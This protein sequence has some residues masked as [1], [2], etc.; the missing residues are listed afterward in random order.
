MTLDEP[1][2]SPAPA[3]AGAGAVNAL[4][5]RIPSSCCGAPAR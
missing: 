4:S 3:D 2:A 1:A 5:D